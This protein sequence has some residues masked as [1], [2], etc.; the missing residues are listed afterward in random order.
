MQKKLFSYFLPST[1][2]GKF[3]LAVPGLG[4]ACQNR[5]MA[6]PEITLFFAFSISF[7]TKYHLKYYDYIESGA[8]M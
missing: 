3:G 8:V 7:Q 4:D 2:V 1:Y 5:K 6:T